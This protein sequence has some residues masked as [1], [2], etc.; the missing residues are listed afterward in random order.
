MLLKPLLAAQ[1][2]TFGLRY[3]TVEKSGRP[4]H[5][6]VTVFFECCSFLQSML[7]WPHLYVSHDV[8]RILVHVLDNRGCKVSYQK[9]GGA[10]SRQV[11]CAVSRY[12]PREVVT[13]FVNVSTIALIS[14]YV[15]QHVVRVVNFMPNLIV[16]RDFLCVSWLGLIPGIT[17]TQ[18]K[19]D[20]GNMLVR[21]MN[22][23]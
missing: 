13:W 17:K 3:R 11:C 21:L 18:L 5:F 1:F 20:L 15:D 8:R 6:G 12:T 16:G 2:V 14:L 19:H 7:L 23:T 4:R 10:A 9:T 22:K